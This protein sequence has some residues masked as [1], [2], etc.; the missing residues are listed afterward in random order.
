M[1]SRTPFIRNANTKTCSN[2]GFLIG[3]NAP[4]VVAFSVASL[5]R[6]YRIRIEF[7]FLPLSINNAKFRKKIL[8]RKRIQFQNFLRSAVVLS[9]REP[10]EMPPM[11]ETTLNGAPATSFDPNFTAP[12]SCPVA[13]IQQHTQ[14]DLKLIAIKFTHP[15]IL[16]SQCNQ[17]CGEVDEESAQLQSELMDLFP[18][19][20]RLCELLFP[21]LRGESLTERRRLELEACIKYPHVLD[22]QEA[23]VKRALGEELT[24]FEELLLRRMDGAVDFS[25]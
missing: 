9:E 13:R 2:S 21:L 15:L 5:L 7:P 12:V 6:A 23:Y 20:S 24:D 25:P 22:L 14:Y 17:E 8:F 4:Y 1:F 18:E 16:E 10:E 3:L 11:L 19:D